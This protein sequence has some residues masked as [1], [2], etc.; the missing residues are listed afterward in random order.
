MGVWGPGNFENDD[1][2]DWLS[3]LAQADDVELLEA[4]LREVI[5][6]DPHWIEAPECCRAI[7]AA[8][9]VASLR[10]APHEHMPDA[11]YAWTVTR[12]V[13]PHAALAGLAHAALSRVRGDSELRALWTSE[14]QLDAW[15]AALG[16][17]ERR[18]GRVDT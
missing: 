2:M 3:E 8:E 1:V 17:L 11:I 4:T 18:L 7:G 16:D 13:E 15:L 12:R 9:V 14:G 10:G 5:D 6:G